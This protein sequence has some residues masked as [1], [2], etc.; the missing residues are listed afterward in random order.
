[1]FRRSKKMSDICNICKW[2]KK[3]KPSAPEPITHNICG[4]NIECWICPKCN[5]Y[6]LKDRAACMG[7]S[8]NWNREYGFIGPTGEILDPKYYNSGVRCGCDK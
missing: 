4:N 5:A 6:T 3:N 2:P 7:Q 8:C 1:M